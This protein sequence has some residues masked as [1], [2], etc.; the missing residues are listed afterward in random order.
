M[1]FFLSKVL[2]FFIQPLA[3]LIVLLLAAAWQ[4]ND[5][6]R[7]KTIQS[8]LLLTCLITNPWLLRQVETWWAVAPVSFS[9]IPNTEVAI[10]LGGFSNP[11]ALPNDR[12]QPNQNAHRLTAALE[13]YK[14]G[15]VQKILI[16]TGAGNLTGP[17]LSEAKHVGQYLQRLGIPDSVVILEPISR[18]T[19]EN[20]SETKRILDSL[21][22]KSCVLITSASHMRRASACFQKQ[23]LAPV[24]CSTGPAGQAGGYTFW[25][26]VM[27]QPEGFVRWQTLIREW[28]GIWAYWAS[29]KI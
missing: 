21:G 17:K 9:S 22:T 20:A 1:F 3:W 10:V 24:L 14:L 6:R 28:V 26:N 19:A 18:N 27:P 2:S 15:K 16:S 4:R 7:R 8:A 5:K 12:Y 11:R 23:G 25:D 13:L 29:G